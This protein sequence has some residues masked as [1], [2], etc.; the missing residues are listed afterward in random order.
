M[1]DTIWDSP[2]KLFIVT[3]LLPKAPV[4]PQL[5]MS[6]QTITVTWDRE[7]QEREEKERLAFPTTGFILR[8]CRQKSSRKDGTFPR[9]GENEQVTEVK[10]SASQST[11][12]LKALSDDCDYSIAISIQTSIGPSEWSTPA[13][14][15][16]EKL[17]SVASAMI[18]FFSENQTSL[19]KKTSSSLWTPWGLDK[20]GRKTT[21][22]LGLKEVGLR[23]TSDSRFPG[24]AVV[25]IVDVA[26]QF[27][28]EIQA[29]DITDIDGTLV[30]VFAGTSGHG[31]STQINA[32]IS[33]L[34]GG[35]TEDEA[36]LM[37]VDD[38][39]ANQADS[40]TQIVNCY[41]IRP[42]NPLFNGKT[43]LV[44]DTPGYGDT[45]GVARDAFVTAAMSEF[46]KTVKHVNAII[47]T[48]RASE[49]RTTILEPVATDAGEHLA[50]ATLRKLEWPI[51]NGEIS[52]NNSA[53]SINPAGVQSGA[54]R[55]GWIQCVRGQFQV[56]QMILS[57]TPI[58]TVNS[59]TVTKSR[60]LLEEKCQLA[61][62]K[63][64]LTVTKAQNLIANL[65]AL[66]NA[67]GAAP[68][69]KVEFTQD[70]AVQKDIAEG[71]ATTLCLDCNF[72][73]HEVCRLGDGLTKYFC[74]AMTSGQCT[75]CRQHCSWKRHTNSRFLIVIE[76]RSSWVVPEEL[77]K[78]WNAN[79]NSLDGALLAAIDTYLELQEGLRNDI[80]EL[81]KLSQELAK[82]ALFKKG[83]GLIKYL[84]QLATA[85]NTL[86]LEAEI[87]GKGEGAT[88]D[89]S[90]LLDVMGAVRKEMTRRME[91]SANDRVAEEE[92]PCNLYNNLHEQLPA[93]IKSK[94][95]P[96]LRTQEVQLVLKDG[97]VVSA[98]AGTAFHTTEHERVNSM[99]GIGGGRN[100]VGQRIDENSFSLR[101]LLK[102][103]AAT[104]GNLFGHN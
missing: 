3:G 1:G 65:R 5:T 14:D 28:P 78:R 75:M 102:Q 90:I 8:Y 35:E 53:F 104:I 9:A 43:I 27:K 19:S 25:R 33:Y 93:E 31:K 61:E 55:D 32:F 69:D 10:F 87:Q 44:V 18:T 49:T 54:F 41:R 45:R 67:V 80:I 79:N 84:A 60:I 21:L 29:S 46:F 17:P 86:I 64:L 24:E 68:G 11:A 88:R 81:A 92:M 56:L 20:S 36:R 23:R 85:K 62:K 71:R 100:E 76:E 97:G 42:L 38:R 58:P 72:T 13:I 70:V 22:F 57:M 39:G 99:V 48:C 37:V 59:A 103:R 7:G 26:P 66:A 51:E 47:F 73:C 40:V 95:P 16:T 74:A 82:R 96:P 94:A 50:H 101:F 98:L 34:F 91:L 4:S 83:P 77:I 15:R 30:V 12:V 2:T 52:V 89:S 6:G 63:V